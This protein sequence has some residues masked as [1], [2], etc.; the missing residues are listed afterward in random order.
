MGVP[1]VEF[2]RRTK[3]LHE[4]KFLEQMTTCGP[5]IERLR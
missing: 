3:F 2:A 1:N 5:K 4:D